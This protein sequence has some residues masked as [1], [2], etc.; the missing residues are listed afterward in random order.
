MDWSVAECLLPC[1][2]CQ[3]TSHLLALQM[4]CMCQIK[5]LSHVYRGKVK[6]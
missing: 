4:R 1:T 3:V 5:H 2:H 6:I